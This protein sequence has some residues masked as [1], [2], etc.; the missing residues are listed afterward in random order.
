MNFGERVREARIRKG[1]SQVELAAAAGLKQQDISAIERRK[2]AK[3]QHAPAIARVLEIPLEEL[4]GAGS[5]ISDLMRLS[6]PRTHAALERIQQ[7]M[8]QGQLTE[9]D[10][11]LLASIAER[12]QQK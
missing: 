1:L 2:Q 10:M 12:L 6:T 3:S 4:L 5:T 11:A 7:A 8:D 9:A